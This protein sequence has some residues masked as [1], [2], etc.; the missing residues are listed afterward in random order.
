MGGE[1]SDVLIIHQASAGQVGGEE[2][3]Q[4]TEEE[5]LMSTTSQKSIGSSPS[6]STIGPSGGASG[7]QLGNERSRR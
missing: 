4:L 1:Q 5:M 6:N 2:M 7:R 3:H